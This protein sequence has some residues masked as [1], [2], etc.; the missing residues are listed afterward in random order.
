MRGGMR[1]RDGQRRGGVKGV[2]SMRMKGVISMRVKG[3]VSMR[4][5]S[6]VSMRVKGVI[7]MRVKAVISTAH[8]QPFPPTDLSAWARKRLTLSG[9]AMPT[10]P[11]DS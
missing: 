8:L 1:D 4:V 6:V 5:K 10:P 7:S 9:M 2:V 3:V 11:K